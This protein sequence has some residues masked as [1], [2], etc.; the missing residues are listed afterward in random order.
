LLVDRIDRWLNC[1]SRTEIP[2][3][4]HPLLASFIK[5]AAAQSRLV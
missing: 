1:C 5:A 4:P 2:F 3:E